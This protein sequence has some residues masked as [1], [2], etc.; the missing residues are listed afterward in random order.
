MHMHCSPKTRINFAD[1][2]FANMLEAQKEAETVINP[3]GVPAAATPSNSWCFC[4]MSCMCCH[5]AHGYM[6]MQGAEL[7]A[8][9]G[10]AFPSIIP[11]SVRAF[12][13]LLGPCD[14][15]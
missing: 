12:D 14:F 13:I 8:V 2:N 3:A 1:V 15:A 6:S 10:M 4:N 9:A 5:H 11:N 7:L